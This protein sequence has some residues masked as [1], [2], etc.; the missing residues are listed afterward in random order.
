MRPNAAWARW[1]CGVLLVAGLLGMRPVARAFGQT[2][3]SDNANRVLA[4][5]RLWNQAEVQK[6]SSALDHLLAR[7]FTFVDVDGT[8]EQKEKFLANIKN[9]PEHISQIGDDTLDP[10]V[11]G[12]III[13]I[14]TYHE[15]GTLNGK[16][17][18]HRARFTDTWIRQGTSWIC[19]AS[20]E[21]YI[22]QT[23][24]GR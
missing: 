2:A 19:V 6:D 23:G 1:G 7:D 22:Q 20:Q 18:Q 14:G 21:T 4:L 10:R 24:E 15:K 8:L 9:P 13:V 11:Y 3:Q 12:D 16:V 17:Y 5:E